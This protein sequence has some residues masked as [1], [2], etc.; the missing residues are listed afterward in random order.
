MKPWQ[1]ADRISGWWIWFL[2]AMWRVYS[3]IW[4]GR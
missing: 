3:K 1:L 4:N 2:R